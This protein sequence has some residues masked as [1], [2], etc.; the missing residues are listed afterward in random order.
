MSQRRSRFSCE[1]SAPTARLCSLASGMD[2]LDPGWGG[3]TGARSSI[4]HPHC[5]FLQ[6]ASPA[7]FLCVLCG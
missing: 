4:P 1:P 6:D 3:A 7:A 5:C 2:A